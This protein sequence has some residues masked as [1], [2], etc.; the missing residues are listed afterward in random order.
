M[1]VA[2]DKIISS[3]DIIVMRVSEITGV[4]IAEFREGRGGNEIARARQVAMYVSFKITT[5]SYTQ[6]GT[7]F[8]RHHTT[9][10]HACKRIV[11]LMEDDEQLEA[12]VMSLFN[13]FNNSEF[14]RIDRDILNA[15][16]HEQLLIKRQLLAIIKMMPLEEILRRLRAPELYGGAQHE[17]QPITKWLEGESKTPNNKYPKEIPCMKCK[18]IFKSK[19]SGNRHCTPCTITLNRADG[20]G[21]S[22]ELIQ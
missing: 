6:V 21:L 15:I 3:L 17:I 19:G 10:M 16:E 22:G 9:V 1:N 12:M 18:T 4:P 14:N 11:E 7:Y 13:K 8:N 20:H 5:K 2:T